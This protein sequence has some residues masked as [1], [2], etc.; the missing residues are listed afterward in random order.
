[1]ESRQIECENY[2]HSPEVEKLMR[3]KQP[4][5]TQYGIT[6]VTLI[7]TIVGVLLFTTE[8]IAQQLMR[9]L[10]NHTMEHIGL[11]L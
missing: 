5:I 1:M 9:G 8:G 6:I 11:K 7:L 4:F 3:G 10:I 2:R